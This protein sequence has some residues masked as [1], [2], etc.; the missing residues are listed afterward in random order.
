MASKSYRNNNP[1][2]LRFTPWVSTL[3]AKNDG[4]DYAKFKTRSEGLAAMVRLLCGPVYRNLSIRQAIYKFAPPKDQNDTESY[5]KDVTDK[6]GLNSSVVLDRL[7]PEEML[8]MIAAMI[9][10]EGWKA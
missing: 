8:G 10:H 1:G 2:N 3:G 9:N 7:S 4:D 5:I 6:T